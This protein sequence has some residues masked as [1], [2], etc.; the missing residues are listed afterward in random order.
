MAGGSRGQRFCERVEAEGYH[1][2]RIHLENAQRYRRGEFTAVVH[3]GEKRD[4]ARNFQP[5]FHQGQQRTAADHI[6]VDQHGLRAAGAIG[7]ERFPHLV[8]VGVGLTPAD[9]FD[10]GAGTG[11]GLGGSLLF[12]VEESAEVL[13]FQHLRQHGDDEDFPVSAFDQVLHPF[14]HGAALVET[15]R[16]QPGEFGVLV[17]EAG[18][19]RGAVAGDDVFDFT[20][21]EILFEIEERATAGLEVEIDLEIEVAFRRLLLELV[22]QLGV[23]QALMQEGILAEG[24]A[25]HIDPLAGADE[26][27]APGHPFD[28]LALNQMLKTFV[29]RDRRDVVDFREFQ[30]GGQPGAVGQF[31]GNDPPC[32]MVGDLDLQRAAGDGFK[33]GHT[34]VSFSDIPLSYQV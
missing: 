26:G 7:E 19:P 24:E 12:V 2:G 3:V 30:R 13:V 18:E 16:L 4:V 8:A 1:P 34:T 15:D 5:K 27:A 23:E 25:D 28:Q 6:V 11:R 21:G 32:Q 29:D 9:H 17:E 10:V 14:F 22:Q 20:A 31:P 33:R